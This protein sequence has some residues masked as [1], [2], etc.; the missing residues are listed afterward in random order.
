V[1]S[2]FLTKDLLTLFL[3]FVRIGSA[4]MVLPGFGD[5]YVTPR[6]RLML[7]LAISVVVSPIVGPTIPDFPDNALAGFVVIGGEAMIGLFLGFVARLVVAALQIAGTVIAYNTGMAN[8]F[9]FDPISA[10]QGA[11]PATFLTILGLVMI[12]V[13]NLHHLM[14]SAVVDSYTLFVPGQMPPVDDF[15]AVV[16]RTMAASFRMALEIAAP[17]IMVGI[18]FYTG[19]GLLARLMPQVQV[20]FIGLPVQITLALIVL[21]LSISAVMMWFLKNFETTL[22]ELLSPG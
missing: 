20:F 18:T 14:L 10:Q 11:L 13:T 15:S 7:A 21:S 8:A 1:L 2:E 4:V 17:F 22:I 12:F 6:F 9:I 19:L 16:A 5:G 3:I